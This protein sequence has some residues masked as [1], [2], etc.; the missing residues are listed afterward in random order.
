MITEK[1]IVD[2]WK[3][4]AIIRWPTL[5]GTYDAV[6]VFAFPLSGQ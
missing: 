1:K 4:S 2:A 6:W 3:Q 5:E